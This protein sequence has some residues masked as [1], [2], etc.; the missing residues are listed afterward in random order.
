MHRFETRIPAPSSLPR[1][2][3]PPAARALRHGSRAA[4]RQAWGVWIDAVAGA[5]G[6]DLVCG[7]QKRGIQ[8]AASTHQ[9]EEGGRY[10]CVCVSEPS[11]LTHS[12][13][14]PYFTGSRLRAMAAAMTDDG[15]SVSA[16]GAAAF[17]RDYA[18]SV[19]ALNSTQLRGDAL[20]RHYDGRT[21]CVEAMRIYL[22]RVGLPEE[23]LR[24]IPTLHVT[25]SKGKGST[26]AFVEAV[27][28]AKGLRTGACVGG[29]FKGGRPWLFVVRSIDPQTE[30]I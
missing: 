4:P 1:T 30:S 9:E 27:L 25:G 17:T 6:R 15:A 28:R 14:T 7:T 16:A 26:C 23:A 22:G 24:R 20:R 18:G 8:S 13:P 12:L 3:G 19:A 10:S 5:G 11:Q 2:I 29:R 21:A